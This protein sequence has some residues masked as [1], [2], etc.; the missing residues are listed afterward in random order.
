[1]P[2]RSILIILTL[3]GTLLIL[4]AAW[5]A[6]SG[7]LSGR[8]SKMAIVAVILVAAIILWLY[9]FLGFHEQVGG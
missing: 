5:A 1:M 3:L 9:P 6:R 2:P 7:R 4:A 8:A